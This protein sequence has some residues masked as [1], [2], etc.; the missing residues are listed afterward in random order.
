MCLRKENH[1]F[2]K[3]VLKPLMILLMFFFEKANGGTDVDLHEFSLLIG[4]LEVNSKPVEQCVFLKPSSH[5]GPKPNRGKQTSK[6]RFSARKGRSNEEERLALAVEEHDGPH[7]PE[8]RGRRKTFQTTA[9]GEVDNEMEKQLSRTLPVVKDDYHE[10]EEV[11]FQVGT[12]WGQA[13]KKKG[14]KGSEKCT[15]VHKLW[16]GTEEGEVSLKAIC[17]AIWFH[18]IFTYL[19]RV[20][21]HSVH[22]WFTMCHVNKENGK[23]S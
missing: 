17:V 18:F 6:P 22:G 11:D 23:H 7:A 12:K 2:H 20:E 8:K 9:N 16:G 10:S 3:T 15:V 21:I 13:K 5:F 14:R 1:K 19:S 4:S